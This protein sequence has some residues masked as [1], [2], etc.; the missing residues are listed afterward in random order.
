M[1]CAGW[2]SINTANEKCGIVHDVII[3]IFQPSWKDFVDVE[4]DGSGSTKSKI[5]NG[6]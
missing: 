3:K 1:L 5:E 6:T 4:I 2:I